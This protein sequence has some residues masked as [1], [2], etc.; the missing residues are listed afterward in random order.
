[1]VVVFKLYKNL[2]DGEEKMMSGR[3]N[4]P[5]PVIIA[6]FFV[7]LFNVSFGEILF[8]AD[9]EIWT[10][11]LPDSWILYPSPNFAVT[12][13]S[14][15]VHEGFRSLKA[16]WHDIS[17]VSIRQNVP[18]IGG[19]CYS[20]SV[21]IYDNDPEGKA[22]LYVNFYNSSDILLNE[23]TSLSSSYT[24][25]LSS[26]QRLA[27]SDAAIPLEAAKADFRVRFVMESGGHESVAYV[28]EASMEEVSKAPYDK[29]IR[30][31]NANNLEIIFNEDV[32]Q[33][34]AETESNY[35][36]DHAVGHPSIATRD[37]VD[38]NKVSLTFAST[39]PST[40]TLT[41]TINGVEDLVGNAT[42]GLAVKFLSGIREPGDVDDV[43]YP[44]GAQIFDNTYATVRG[45]VIATEFIPEEITIAGIVSSDGI[46]VYNHSAP[47][48]GVARGDIV[49]VS[50]RIG[51][52]RGTA[53]IEGSPVFYEVEEYGCTEPEPQKVSLLAITNQSEETINAFSGEPYEGNLVEIEDVEAG[54]F[55][56]NERTGGVEDADGY[57]NANA[58]YELYHDWDT[59]VIHI[60]GGKDIDGYYINIPRPLCGSYKLE[61]KVEG[62]RTQYKKIFPPDFKCGYIIQNYRGII[63]QYKTSSPYHSGYMLCPRD[64]PDTYYRHLSVDPSWTLYE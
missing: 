22:F 16:A 36:I 60:Y 50:G 27:I 61:K 5:I 9:F 39:L 51:Q 42:T 64:I 38:H 21:W 10:G 29:N 35:T 41:L 44:D 55:L 43:S 48:S 45:I 59:G 53:R 46:D 34:G 63:K 15:N 47:F 19:A 4:C 26:W 7:S 33:A 17:L 49:L 24:T 23:S 12:E 11:G 20:F 37:P 54:Y 18:V 13:T 40:G 31:L 2:K 62:S 57:W 25:D 52:Y 14:E 32:Q 30:I 56:D 3:F 6:F 1:M 58:N 8:N 28:D